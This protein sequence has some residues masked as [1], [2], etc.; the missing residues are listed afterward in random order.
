MVASI[1]AQCQPQ[2]GFTRISA[3]S[4]G[5]ARRFAISLRRGWPERAHMPRLGTYHLRRGPTAFTEMN[6][7]ECAPFPLPAGRLAGGHAAVRA[8]R[9]GRPTACRPVASKRQLRRV[10]GPN[11]R[12]MP[13]GRVL[14]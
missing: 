8:D 9:P 7:F 10:E 12:S 5:A 13:R 6:A 14:Q 3:A 11:S 2:Y 1:A 4:V